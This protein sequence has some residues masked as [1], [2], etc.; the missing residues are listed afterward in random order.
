MKA[1]VQFIVLKRADKWVI[2][3]QDAERAFPAQH[4]A[5]EAAIKLANDSGKNGTPAVVLCQRSKTDFRK[6][7]TY[8]ESAYPP[9]KSDL[10]VVAQVTQ[11]RKPNRPR[12]PL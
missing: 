6:V 5:L 4:K 10:S 11:A 1:P 12:P 9:T 3:W 7:W 2:K 8:G